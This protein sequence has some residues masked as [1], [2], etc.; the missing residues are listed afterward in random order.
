MNAVW[1]RFCKHPLTQFFA[2][3]K[4][5]VIVISSSI[6]AM[7]AG[8]IIESLYG[9][10]FAKRLVYDSKLFW[11]IFILLFLNVLFAALVRF[12]YKKRLAGFYFIH[13]GILLVLVG[14]TVTYFGGIDGILE[15]RPQKPTNR[16]ILEDP[17]LYAAY[18]APGDTTARQYIIDLPEV[19]WEV[20]GSRPFLQQG[21]YD[22]YM[23]RFL[24]YAEPTLYAWR[25]SWPMTPT[26][27]KDSA[28]LLRVVNRTDPED[29]GTVWTRPNDDATLTLKNGQFT[30]FIGQKIHKLDFSISL[31][32]FK[33][34]TNPGTNE[35]ASYESV[36]QVLSPEGKEDAHVYM[37]HPL[38]KG[39]YT[40]YQSSYFP[41]PDGTGFGSVF[42]V[43]YD[44]GRALKYTGSAILV[45]GTILHYYLR[46][47]KRLPVG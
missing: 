2:S 8:T 9:R 19:V 26:E 40:L 5:A 36:V 41:L 47:K 1:T 15:L 31:D 16:V 33:M 37:N 13:L 28:A 23:D 25:K 32:Y 18:R 42:S 21:P 44:P 46:R 20:R 27:K 29:S 17:V 10:E 24:P 45:G 35:P 6:I 4:L 43:N 30:F 34:D 11:G 38:K 7:M 12:P 22:L 3:L 14:S 39:L